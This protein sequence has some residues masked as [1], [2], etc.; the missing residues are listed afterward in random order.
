MCIDVVEEGAH[1]PARVGNAR[2]A[3]LFLQLWSFAECRY[4]WS[5]FTAAGLPRH[6]P[7]L[8]CPPS[9]MY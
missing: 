6:F 2:S 4:R 9:L 1:D 7:P 3:S 5:H 8:L